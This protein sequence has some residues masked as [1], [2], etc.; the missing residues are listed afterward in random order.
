MVLSCMRMCDGAIELTGSCLSRWICMHVHTNKIQMGNEMC[1]CFL[2]VFISQYR[3]LLWGCVRA[4]VLFSYQRTRKNSRIFSISFPHSHSITSSSHFISYR[5]ASHAV[6]S[7]SHISGVENCWR[8]VISIIYVQRA[9][10]HIHLVCVYD[11]DYF[12]V[13]L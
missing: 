7:I 6:V 2:K 8:L 4:R 9:W 5:I 3:Y 13:L 12:G 1:T 11:Y 10:I